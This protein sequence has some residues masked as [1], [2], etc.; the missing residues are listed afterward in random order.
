MRKSGINAISIEEGR[1]TS[2]PLSR[3]AGPDQVCHTALQKVTR[4]ERL[5]VLEVI[6]IDETCLQT[7]RLRLTFIALGDEWR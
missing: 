4:K 3:E 6:G 2:C 5:L 1:Q 7:Q